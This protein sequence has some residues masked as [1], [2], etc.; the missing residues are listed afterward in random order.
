M[1]RTQILPSDPGAIK[2]WD[3]ESGQELLPLQ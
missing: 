2:L 1:A 3:T